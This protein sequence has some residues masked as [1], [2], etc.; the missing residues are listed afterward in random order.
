MIERLAKIEFRLLEELYK[1]RKKTGRRDLWLATDAHK[2]L[3]IKEDGEDIAVLHDSPYFSIKLNAANECFQINAGGIRY[4]ENLPSLL[5][6]NLAF[7]K[8]HIILGL[9]GGVLIIVL[10]AYI[11]SRLDL[12]GSEKKLYISTQTVHENGPT[13][14]YEYI[15]LGG[16]GQLAQMPTATFDAAIAVGKIK[17]EMHHFYLYQV[18]A[19]ALDPSVRFTEGEALGNTSK[20]AYDS[21]DL[22]LFYLL[23]KEEREQTISA[24]G[25]KYKV[26][27]LTIDGRRDDQSRISYTFR[28]EELSE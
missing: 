4:M 22:Y 9:M 1:R 7:I 24:G 10:G 21:E 18:V 8:K 13:V 5:H 3:G 27:L 17:G 12:D 11:V 25:K 26:T 19:M 2:F 15:D 20:T 6:K 28:V 23:N 14:P 16:R